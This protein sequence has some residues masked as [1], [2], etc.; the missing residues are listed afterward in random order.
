MK[1]RIQDCSCVVLAK[2]LC[3][4]HY[5]KLRSYGD[6]LAG[7]FEKVKK[8]YGSMRPNGYHRRSINGKEKSQHVLIAEKALGRFL[9]KGAQVHHVNGNGL[10][11]RSSNLVICQDQAYHSLLHLRTKAI[12]ECGNAN[13]RKC[14]RCGRYDDPDNL[15]INK[16]YAYHKSCEAEYQRNRR[17]A[18]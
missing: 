1:C 3:N 11:N 10:D 13:W 6:P 18:K 9:P 17:C 7:R 14:Y 16:K 15:S 5:K 4:K 12:D 8:G 2:E